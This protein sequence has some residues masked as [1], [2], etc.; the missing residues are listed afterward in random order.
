MPLKPL[1]PD[2]AT[3]RITVIAPER[4]RLVLHLEPLRRAVACPVCGTQSQRVHS[5]Y[6][7]KPWNLPW[8]GWPVQLV[9]H[10]RRF[11]CDTLT[12]SRRIFVEPFPAKKW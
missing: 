9:V 4:D 2:P 1:C 10:A 8:G 3:W 11:F 7:C 5:R 12:C 6:R